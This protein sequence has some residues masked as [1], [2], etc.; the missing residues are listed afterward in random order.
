MP[1]PNLETQLMERCVERENML[2]AWKRVR[3]NGGS[4]GVDGLGIEESAK[5]L[6]TNWPRIRMELLCGSYKPSSVRKVEIAKSGGGVRQ[7]GIPT[8]TD[9]LV[10]QC[11]L[12][13]LQP[14]WD[15]TFHQNSFGFRPGK[16]AHQAICQ[17]QKYVQEGRDWVVDVD[18]EKFF[19]RV[20]HDILMDR[21]MKR[22]KDQRVVS[23]IR[24]YLRAGIMDH[25]VCI[26]RDEGTPQG[27]PLSPLLANLLLNEV[28]W[29]LE[30]RGL[31]FCRYADDCNIYVRSERSAQRAMQTMQKLMAKLRLKINSSKSAVA[32]AKDRKFLGFRL[33]KHKGVVKRA[34]APQ[35]L[36][37]FKERVRTLTSRTSG[38]S[39]EEIVDKLDSYLVGWRGY[40]RLSD[41]PTIFENLDGWIRR[42]LR[43][44]QLK[45]WK[46]GTTIYRELRAKGVG[47]LAAATS[48]DGSRGWWHR[49]GTQGMHLGLPTSFFDR[50]ELSHLKG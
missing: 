38:K 48:S 43:M 22:V 1:T 42:R 30:K 50:L 4:A 26:T 10:Q 17:A 31:A 11:V 8:V 24:S 25:G 29:E 14:L 20:N 13:V 41:T 35:S 39:M 40:F 12:Q 18:L 36:E 2:K 28:D 21:V 45:H 9:R 47:K 49:S 32:K 37:K 3:Q 5:Y 7:L 23:L 6:K 44:V 16:S 27:G 33:W 19:D 34:V 46:R 15:P